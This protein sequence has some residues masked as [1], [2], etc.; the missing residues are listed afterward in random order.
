MKAKRL[1]QTVL[2]LLLTLT[3]SCEQPPPPELP[4]ASPEALA[5]W[6]QIPEG[7]KREHRMSM[8]SSPKTL[9]MQAEFRSL[10]LEMSSHHRLTIQQYDEAVTEAWNEIQGL[11][12]QSRDYCNNRRA[13]ITPEVY[14]RLILIPAGSLMPVA[15]NLY[16][17]RAAE[18]ALI[19]CPQSPRIGCDALLRTRGVIVRVIIAQKNLCKWPLLQGELEQELSIWFAGAG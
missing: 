4:A 15:P 9:L 18:N 16:I 1:S 5:L 8:L 6:S 10:T 7:E 11:D 3:L 12:Y 14:R 13:L 2:A 19:G 17:S